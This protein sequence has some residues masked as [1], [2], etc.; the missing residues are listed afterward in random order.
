MKASQDYQIAPET[1]RIGL[2]FGL[3]TYNEKDDVYELTDKGDKYLK[4][5]CA[6]QISIARIMAI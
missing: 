2:L 5:W 3:M 1:I 4:E 6:E